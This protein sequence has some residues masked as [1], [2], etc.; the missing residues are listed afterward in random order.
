MKEYEV[1]IE[2][3]DTLLV[4]VYAK[5][6]NDAYDKALE[7]WRN[8]DFEDAISLRDISLDNDVNIEVIDEE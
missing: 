3:T 1:K 8:A 4:K 2:E 5:N 6:K 7:M